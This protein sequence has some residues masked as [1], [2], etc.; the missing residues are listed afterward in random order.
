LTQAGEASGPFDG[1]VELAERLAQ[2]D[3]VRG[4][5]TRQWF[6]YR[7]GRTETDDDACTLSQLSEDFANSD[8]D[9]RTLLLEL[10]VSDAFRLVRGGER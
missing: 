2:S 5:V 3:A 10:V 7:L 8:Y 1:A 9:V 4:C 6:R